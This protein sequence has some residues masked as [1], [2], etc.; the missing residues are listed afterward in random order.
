MTFK[1]LAV[2][3]FATLSIAFPLVAQM[4]MGMGARIPTL[5]GVW[6]PE[7]GSGAAY[8]DTKTDGRKV[9]MEIIIVG[10]E[11][12]DGKTAYWTEMSSIDPRTSSPVYVKILMAV[13]GN[14]VT[15][16]RM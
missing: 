15:S 9:N 7:V 2:A 3:L 16:G 12:V 1:Q 13:S 5:S 6:H 8:E 4:G 11:D 14:T 10:K